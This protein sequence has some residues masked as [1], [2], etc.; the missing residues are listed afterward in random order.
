M[1][2]IKAKA[3][4]LM[5]AL[6][7]MS[8][9]AAYALQTYDSS[10]VSS[11]IEGVVKS[12]ILPL[13]GIITFIGVIIIGIQLIVNANSPEKRAKTATALPWIAGGCLLLGGA[14]VIAGLIL[15]ATQTFQQ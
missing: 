11:K 7:A 10:T 4:C 3:S 15:G 6:I 2:R 9:R 8:Q 1:K 13:G 14:A 5:A 12:Y